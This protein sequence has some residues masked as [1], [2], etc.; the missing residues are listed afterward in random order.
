MSTKKEVTPENLKTFNGLENLTD[1]QA[2]E[3]HN[4]LDRYATLLAKIFIRE[5]TE[6]QNSNEH[7]S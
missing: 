2:N 4:Q 3:L 5:T 1:E 6:Q 7:T